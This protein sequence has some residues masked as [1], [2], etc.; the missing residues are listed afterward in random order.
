MPCRTRKAKFAASAVKIFR[1]ASA[2]NFSIQLQLSR[3]RRLLCNFAA[4]FALCVSSVSQE[5]GLMLEWELLSVT[6]PA[7]LIVLVV[8][9]TRDH[10]K[11]IC[12]TAKSI[13]LAEHIAN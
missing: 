1:S 9:V 12:Y 13:K 7:H 6:S 8:Q 3:W 10:I 4:G 2:D 11:L 5:S